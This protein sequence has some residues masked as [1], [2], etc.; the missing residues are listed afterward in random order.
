[1]A[2]MGCVLGLTGRWGRILSPVS[3]QCL[4]D[5]SES[6]RMRGPKTALYVLGTIGYLAVMALGA[7]RL[8]FF[9]P[10]GEPIGPSGWGDVL[11]GLFSPLA[12]LWL[13]YAS[14]SQRAELELQREELRLNNQTQADQ[15]REMGRQADALAAQ[16]R[17]LEAQAT[18]T[19]EPVF[20]LRK[21]KGSTS[22]DSFI[23]LIL[24]NE[25]GTALN[26]HTPASLTPRSI[27]FS[28]DSLE[29]SLKTRVI[30]YWPA[31]ATVHFV[32]D[33]SAMEDREEPS[34]LIAFRRL[35]TVSVTHRYLLTD[36]A[37]RMEL[38]EATYED[39]IRE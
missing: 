1:M 9:D 30:S 35:D 20:V 33:M 39:D 2:S 16:T 15:Q 26:V 6:K 27:F 36:S 17:R 34:F 13:L 11:A 4:N 29:T 21:I 22:R 25:G 3:H 28:G 18:A 5:M 37:N 31:N 24:K 19:Y 7:W 10:A 12:F 32:L 8:G 38:R 23:T 14:L